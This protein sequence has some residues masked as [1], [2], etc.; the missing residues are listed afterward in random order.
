MFFVYFGQRFF[1]I[2][3]FANIFFPVGG[4]FY[5]LIS[6]FHR[7]EVLRFNEVQLIKFSFMAHVFG[8]VSKKLSPYPVSSRYFPVL[9]SK[10]I[11]LHFTLRS[12]LY[13]ELIFVRGIRSVSGFAYLSFG[14]WMSSCSATFAE[15]TF[16]TPLCCLCSFVKDQ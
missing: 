11:V 5:S 9:S 3:V 12:M 14:M 15:M 2:C 16:F 1:I 6:V 7:A 13:F 8:V 10:T 4:L